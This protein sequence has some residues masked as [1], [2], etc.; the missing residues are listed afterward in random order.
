MD[1]RDSKASKPLPDTETNANPSLSV[2]AHT[3]PSAA[4]TERAD[5]VV[6]PVCLLPAVH[7]PSGCGTIY[8]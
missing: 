4:L 5:L 3:C 6:C 2:N 8:Y 1:L 7:G